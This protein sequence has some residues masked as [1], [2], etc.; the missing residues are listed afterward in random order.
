MKLKKVNKI[1]MNVYY[2]MVKS[3][4]ISRIL[5]KIRLRRKKKIKRIR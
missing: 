2:K 5:K 1:H 4:V 3:K